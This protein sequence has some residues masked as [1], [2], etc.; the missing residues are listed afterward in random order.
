MKKIILVL[1]LLSMVYA[2]DPDRNSEKMQ[3]S[4]FQQGIETSSY[5]AIGFSNMLSS[6][7]C[8]IGNGNPATLS[9]FNNFSVGL[10]YDYTSKIDPFLFDELSFHRT[11]DWYPNSLGIVYPIGK[12]SL[13]L[14]YHKKYSGELD[15]GDIEITTIEN[16]EGDPNNTYT[17]EDETFISSYSG[18]ISYSNTD[19]FYSEDKLSVGLQISL[20]HFYDYTKIA[21]TEMEYDANDM[22]WKMGVNYKFSQLLALGILYEKGVDIID[23]IDYPDEYGLGDSYDPYVVYRPEK[24]IVELPDRIAYGVQLYPIEKL[25]FASTISQVFWN[26]L[27]NDLK[28]LFS[29]PMQ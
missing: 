10:H 11:K 29:F 15:W 14:A 8:G 16:P 23:N 27:Y 7:I 18:I 4:L 28:I 26:D 2:G 20:D 1:V 6:E 24:F 21:H 25:S 9:N 13:G 3:I 22:S 12:F 5:N 19:I 17:I